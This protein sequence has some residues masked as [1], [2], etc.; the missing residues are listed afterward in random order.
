[1]S[2]IR[3]INPILAEDTGMV[4]VIRG[5]K[6]EYTTALRAFSSD[7]L[8]PGMGTVFQNFNHNSRLLDL[9]QYTL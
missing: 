4:R 1:M 5:V 8:H 2:A 9:I 3:A 6:P 7:G